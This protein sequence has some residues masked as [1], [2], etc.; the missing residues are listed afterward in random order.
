MFHFWFNTFFVNDREICRLV[1]TT[2]A[3]DLSPSSSSDPPPPVPAE[4]STPPTPATP[5][6]AVTPDPKH[7]AHATRERLNSEWM[8]NMLKT[9]Q[10][11]SP[12][13]S[14]SSPPPPRPAPETSSGSTP[15]PPPHP[16]SSAPSSAKKLPAGQRVP[17][18]NW[19]RKFSAGLDQ[20]YRKRTN[21]RT[22]TLYKVELDKVNK[23]MTHRAVAA[24]FKVFLLICCI[25][26]AL[27]PCP[28]DK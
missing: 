25:I 22:L 27:H 2:P 23:D 1:E 9:M 12:G 24:N 6:G 28:I 5:A 19:E 26:S 10:N 3:A 16:P 15:P 18:E 4:P 7:E 21:Y 8:N 17:M 11:E 14:T 13:G 20:T